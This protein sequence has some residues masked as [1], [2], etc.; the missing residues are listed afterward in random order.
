MNTSSLVSALGRK[1]PRRSIMERRERLSGRLDQSR[2]ELGARVKRS[3]PHPKHVAPAGEGRALPVRA[4]QAGLP[5]ERTMTAIK[6]LL[7]GIV[8]LLLAL[9][10]MIITAAITYDGTC[11]SLL[12]FMGTS[13]PCSLVE[14]LHNDLSLTLAAILTEFWWGIAAILLIPSLVG[15]LFE[16][17]RRI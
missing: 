1:S 5:F 10:W 4:R 3:R 6:G 2:C 17:K 16:K 7:A 11:G 12:P 15:Y 9:A 8:I 13:R 14:Y